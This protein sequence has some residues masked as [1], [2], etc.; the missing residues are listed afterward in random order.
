M[1]KV[2]T[3]EYFLNHLCPPS[4]TS[5]FRH[6]HPPQ[7][8]WQARWGQ[9]LLGAICAIN[10]GTLSD[11]AAAIFSISNLFALEKP[12]GDVRPLAIGECLRRLAASCQCSQEA[13]AFNEFF[14]GGRAKNLAFT[15]AGTDVL[16]HCIALLLE[17][18]PTRVL[19]ADDIVNGFN[20]ILR[21][22]I[23]KGLASSPHAN[24]KDAASLFYASPS[25]LFS[26]GRTLTSSKGV[27]HWSA[28]G[29]QQGD[30]LGPA[31][32][33]FGY[34]PAVEEAARK[35]PSCWFF[36]FMDDTYIIGPDAATAL[37]A[38]A[39]KQEVAR[40]VCG[41]ESNLEKVEVFSHAG[42]L[43]AV[44][45][46]F[47]GSP[48]HP[49]GALRGLR[50]VGHFVGEPEWIKAMMQ[51]MVTR[52]L[53]GLQVLEHLKDDESR[54]SSAMIKAI[55]TRFCANHQ[56]SHLLHGCPPDLMEGAAVSHDR[57]ITDTFLRIMGIGCST[58][59][60]IERAR[61][62]L[63][64]PVS[65]GGASIV[66]AARSRDAAYAGSLLS[67]WEFI[68]QRA[69]PELRKLS[70]ALDSPSAR[71]AAVARSLE[72]IRLDR[73][74]IGKM[75]D[76]FEAKPFYTAADGVSHFRYHPKGL[77]TAAAIPSLTSLENP[78]ELQTL[79]GLQHKLTTVAN[80]RAWV[81]C[82][83]SCSS[84]GD[85]REA[86]RFLSCSQPHAHDFLNV[87]PGD[88]VSRLTSPQWKVVC[89]Y[90]FGL[91]LTALAEFNIGSYLGDDILNDQAHGNRHFRV[92]NAWSDAFKAIH[93]NNWEREPGNYL[94]YSP[95][96]R[97]DG[98]I[99]E[100][101]DGTRRALVE[102]K[103]ASP[104][105]TTGGKTSTTTRSATVAMSATLPHFINKCVGRPNQLVSEL[106]PFPDYKRSI[107]QGNVLILLVHEV[108]GAMCPVA[109]KTLR[110]LAT[111]VDNK[112]SDK[113]ARHASWTARSFMAFHAQR[114]SAAIAKSVAMEL[115]AA[116]GPVRWGP[117]A[118][119]REARRRCEAAGDASRAHRHD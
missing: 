66:S 5:T 27:E 57:R 2:D 90:H 31:Y 86:T 72:R 37:A 38:L 53:R 23:D 85:C 82:M 108:F 84:T 7:A 97:P 28:T 21:S 89:Q 99:H 64:I 43:T 96:Y 109:L 98:T 100:Y 93:G 41:L 42:D 12:N 47:K 54:S 103:V 32:F 16:F 10:D 13:A 22:A 33:C 73:N 111:D 83:A 106:G 110:K 80:H 46:S 113:Y 78:L 1:Y 29:S 59:A 70:I 118:L 6:S 18:D 9:A 105:K 102:N 51:T 71:L 50:I 65:M 40:D 17:Q 20:S 91:N 3:W 79:R 45:A 19:I 8:R 35:F 11:E 30:P 107:A 104:C 60:Q 36:V 75:Y 77:P 24:L 81:D 48:K 49:G 4:R 63:A 92:L 68:V 119:A 112:L 94:S 95:D 25:R 74:L 58:R 34:Q 56:I 62:Q 114:I 69:C 52:K 55:L 44:P 15:R 117:Y 26:K 88:R 39:Y 67:A 14:T 116:W 101:S 87:M 115:L 76:T 61:M